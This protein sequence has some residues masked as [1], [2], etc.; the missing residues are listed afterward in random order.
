[1]SN[2]L[3][4]VRSIAGSS[5]KSSS[6]KYAEPCRAPRLLLLLIVLSNLRLLDSTGFG[7]LA[8]DALEFNG[9]WILV[10]EGAVLDC[11]RTALPNMVDLMKAAGDLKATLRTGNEAFSQQIVI[12]DKDRSDPPAVCLWQ[13]RL[14]LQIRSRSRFNA[15]RSARLP[16]HTTCDISG[17]SICWQAPRSNTDLCMA[18]L[19]KRHPCLWHVVQAAP[20]GSY[21]QSTFY[22]VH[23]GWAVCSPDRSVLIRSRL[24][25]MPTCG[26]MHL[27]DYMLD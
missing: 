8:R 18:T 17:E 27:H 14:R 12:H 25:T 26:S 22:C 5:S 24:S 4:P 19:D 13:L 2:G 20:R 11:C 7:M 21:I 1:M 9:L 15:S 6:S 3:V 23:G 10:D 16:S